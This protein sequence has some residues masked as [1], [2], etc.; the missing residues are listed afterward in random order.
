MRIMI[1]TVSADMV[2]VRTTVLN[3][4]SLEGHRSRPSL[5]PQQIV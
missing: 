3:R 4:F 1:R 5:N 2:T